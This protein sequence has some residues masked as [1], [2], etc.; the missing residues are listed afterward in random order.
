MSLLFKRLPIY[1][2]YVKFLGCIIIWT[3]KNKFHVSW[4]CSFA[5]SQSHHTSSLDIVLYEEWSFFKRYTLEWPTKT[6]LADFDDP[7]PI[8][9][10]RIGVL[11]HLW[12]RTRPR[13]MAQSPETPACLERERQEGVVACDR[14]GQVA[15]RDGYFRRIGS[16]NP[17]LACI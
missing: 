7:P 14:T 4:F 16:L 15:G 5:N 13:W 8:S 11:T 6:P 17:Y 10:G 2:G 12:H 1:R 9:N 3:R